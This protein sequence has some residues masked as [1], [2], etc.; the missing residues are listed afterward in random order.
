MPQTITKGFR[1]MLE[2][3][4]REVEAKNAVPLT[5]VAITCMSTIRA[6]R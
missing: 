1:E 3:A 4:E 5:S 6:S 2:E